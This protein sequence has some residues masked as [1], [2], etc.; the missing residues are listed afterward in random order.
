MRILIADDH[1]IFRQGLLKV[2]EGVADIE[3]VA[4][5]GDGE[6]ALHLIRRHQPNVALLDIS[7]PGKSGLEIAKEI[8]VQELP[9]T[10]IILTMFKEEE[11]FNEALDLGV[12]GYVLKDNAV[13]DILE[14]LKTV[15]Q[16]KYYVSPL[17][18]QY[19]IH[20][21]QRQRDF[22][23]QIPALQT[24]TPMERRVLKLIAENRTSKEIAAALFI[25][26]RTVQNHRNNICNKLS[27][28]GPHKL[29]QFALENK[30]LL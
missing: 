9:T 17:I 2:I 24:L 4:E 21:T 22:Y 5:T 30:A 15:S 1:P 6:T 28:K 18:S 12:K 3:V 25:S 23:V 14:C 19:L 7:M 20:R 29:L 16:G 26:F 27:L 11:Y 10:V 8:Q 13:S